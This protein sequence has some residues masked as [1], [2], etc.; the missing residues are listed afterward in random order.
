[1][2]KINRRG[3]LNLNIQVSSGRSGMLKK[4]VEH[5]L[6]FTKK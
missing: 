1:M 5:K 6:D 2:S 4:T 3:P